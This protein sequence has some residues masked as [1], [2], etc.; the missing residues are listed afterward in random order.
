MG[1]I[2]T[3]SPISAKPTLMAKGDKVGSGEQGGSVLWHIGAKYEGD[4]PDTNRPMQEVL[5]DGSASGW[6]EG[7]QEQK[8][9]RFN[10]SFS[11]GGMGG[12]KVEMPATK[13][14]AKSQAG[15]QSRSL[16]ASELKAWADSEIAR[17]QAGTDHGPPPAVQPAMDR[18]AAE[19]EQLPS[20]QPPPWLRAYMGDK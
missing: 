5:S 18:A 7:A 17:L 12:S 4:E 6:I 15:G 3:F 2:P 19:D 11:G 1:S 10:P 20:N 13:P 9:D 8:V 16:S 14:Q